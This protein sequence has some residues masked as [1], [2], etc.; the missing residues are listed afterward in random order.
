MDSSHYKVVKLTLIFFMISLF[1]NL[2]KN[3]MIVSHFNEEVKSVVGISSYTSLIVGI[4]FTCIILLITSYI[5]FVVIE[6]FD[7]NIS[8]LEFSKSFQI[9]IYVLALGELLKLILALAIL[10]DELRFLTID[11]TFLEQFEATK[12]F[13]YNSFIEKGIMFLSLIF[14][15]FSFKK[16]NEFKRLIH[17]AILSF[18][19]LFS[20]IISSIN[21][22][23]HP[24]L[25]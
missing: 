4:I 22:I 25:C 1:C 13:Y 19:I 23:D 20:I 9:M 7:L 6:I 14:F 16:L 8:L 5:C 24:P 18:L 10:D 17:I 15:I 11:D 2:F 21:W 3:F 12:W